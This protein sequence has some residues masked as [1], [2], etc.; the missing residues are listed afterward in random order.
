MAV[1]LCNMTLVPGSGIVGISSRA[2]MIPIEVVLAVRGVLVCRKLTGS[3]IGHSR[4]RA[5]WN[6]ADNCEEWRLSWGRTQYRNS[7]GGC[8]QGDTESQEQPGGMHLSWLCDSGFGSVTSLD[9]INS[10][11]ALDW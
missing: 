1:S 11:C 7:V 3:G 4:S 2:I 5:F 9:G 8:G 10:I 6:A